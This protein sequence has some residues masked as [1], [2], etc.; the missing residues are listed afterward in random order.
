[1]K[2]DLMATAGDID[3]IKD[4]YA[5]YVLMANLQQASTSEQYTKLL[6][7]ISKPHQVQQNDNNV[8]PDASSVEQSGGT[9]DQIPVTAT[10]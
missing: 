1:E 6:K 3:E 7:P 9:V 10:I 8:I 5:N 2:F 4:V